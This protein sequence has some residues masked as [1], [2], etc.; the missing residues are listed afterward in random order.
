MTTK[1]A[2]ANVTY[3]DPYEGYTAADDA[4]DRAAAHLAPNPAW[5][6]SA[7]LQREAEGL[8]SDAELLLAAARPSPA[9]VEAR[10][11]T[12]QSATRRPA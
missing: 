1:P 8:S 12:E 6:E 7:A 3:M 11:A 2:A 10:I 5:S 4:R 9:E